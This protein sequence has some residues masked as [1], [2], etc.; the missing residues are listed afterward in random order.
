MGV[1][2]ALLDAGVSPGGS[3]QLAPEGD[4]E[5]FWYVLERWPDPEV[6]NG[7]RLSTPSSIDAYRVLLA[8][9]HRPGDDLR[10][11]LSVWVR[12][13]RVLG[14]TVAVSSGDVVI[15]DLARRLYPPPEAD[16]AGA[17]ECRVSVYGRPM[18]AESTFTLEP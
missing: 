2:N 12:E 1:L 7:P 10:C 18:P 5:W 16:L 15:D 3:F 9:R 14:A 13:R 4:R 17:E 8:S 11:V 6:T